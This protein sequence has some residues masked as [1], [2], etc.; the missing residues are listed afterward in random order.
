MPLSSTQIGAIGENLLANAVMKA[1]DDRLSPFQPLADDDGLDVLFF[2][3]LTGNSVAIQLKC[4]TVT[5]RSARQRTSGV[6]LNKETVI[7]V[8]GLPDA[9]SRG[10]T[11]EQIPLNG[12][13]LVGRGWRSF[14]GRPARHADSAAPYCAIDLFAALSPGPPSPFLPIP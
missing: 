13:S 12:S 3:K 11:F 6:A 1:S 7:V 2:D 9:R 10:D 14:N 4:R 8:E 5:M